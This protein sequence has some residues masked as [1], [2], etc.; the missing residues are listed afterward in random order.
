MKNKFA[1]LRL[2]CFC[3]LP[4]VM[5]FDAW[6]QG[7]AF[8]YQGFLTDQGAPATGSNDLTFTLFTTSGGS[9]VVGT[10]NVVNDLAI[11]NGLFSTTLDFGAGVFTGQD[12]WLQ[13]A[14]RP[15]AS[16]GP[17][18][19]VTPRQR[20]TPAPYAIF[21]GSSSN[22]SGTVASGGLSGT[23]SNPLTFSNAANSIR[24]TFTGNGFN[25]S[26]VNAVAL[27]GLPAAAFW[28]LNGNNVGGN[29]ILGS[30]NNQVVQLVANGF[31]ALRLE[32]NSMALPNLVGGNGNGI[33]AGVYGAV[34][35]G[36]F[37]N[38]IETNAVESVIA[39]GS[40]NNIGLDSYSTT[41][42][43]GANNKILA[44]SQNATVVGGEANI[45]DTNCAYAFMGG[46]GQNNIFGNNAYSFLG[47]GNANR[48]LI[49]AN[50]GFVGGGRN[51]TNGATTSVIAGG[52]G[53][54]VQLLADRSFIGGGLRNVTTGALGMVPGGFA[55]S[56]GGQAFAAGRRAKAN[57][58]GSFVWADSTDADFASSVANQVNMRA[59]GGYR[60][61][62]NAGAT[63]GVQIASGGNAWAPLSDRNLKE[64][65]QPVDCRAFLEKVAALPL[66]TW[67]LKSQPTEIRHIG[68]MAQ[69]FQAAFAVGED[70][71][72]ISTSDADGVALAAI[73]GLNQ[74]MD[75]EN[76]KLRGE[77]KQKETEIAEL[78]QRLDALEKSIR[79]LNSN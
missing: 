61:F 35:G 1:T 31:N 77:L 50:Y 74:K 54:S 51:N 73:Q 65:F 3:S 76:A 47:G 32:P 13:I 14:V 69:D 68:V 5:C 18:T 39:G 43:G 40:F 24:G 78:K 41:I 67:N 33:A 22:L 30:T 57:D 19:N 34:I 28:Q 25:V 8:T 52:E 7:T 48:I 62:S 20:I 44:N 63:V 49:G 46:G 60:L 29:Q 55:N 56:A 11:S 58:T 37:A 23:Y 53:N 9:S 70:D 36:G 2:L 4:A 38:G 75:S 79:K 6:A 64:N 26:N 71:R 10:S 42:G 72:H 59:S 27:S 17:Y 12:R 21:A 66:T 15:G 45:V 16:S